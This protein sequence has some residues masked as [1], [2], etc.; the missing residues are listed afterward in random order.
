MRR[1]LWL[2][3]MVDAVACRVQAAPSHPGKQPVP[4]ATAAMPG[5]TST[6]TP[7]SASGPTIDG[8]VPS[9]RATG[10]SAIANASEELSSTI[11]AINASL[12]PLSG[13][14]WVIT[15]TATNRRERLHWLARDFGAPVFLRADQ[16]DEGQLSKQGA[17]PL[18]LGVIAIRFRTCHDLAAAKAKVDRSGRQNFA[19]PVLTLFRTR[20]HDHALVFI[21][22]E[23]PA[24]ESAAGVLRNALR[25]SD[26]ACHDRS[27]L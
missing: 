22:S 15:G 21:F 13:A 8:S 20:S 16:L 19:L 23:T 24:H 14:A 10:K 3:L 5:I 17:L 1:A 27:S 18:H 25:G 7:A 2:A 12:P 11:G 9:E 4:D 6:P 26:R